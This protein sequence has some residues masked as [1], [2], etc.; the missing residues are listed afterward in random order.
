MAFARSALALYS[1]AW[2]TSSSHCSLA[3]S[4]CRSL[5]LCKHSQYELQQKYE[6]LAFYTNEAIS[7][8]RLSSAMHL[9]RLSN[10]PS[11]AQGGLAT[12]HV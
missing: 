8:E 2:A 1:A 11:L 5:P 9:K 3:T 10:A 6:L 12:D 7:Q 4:A